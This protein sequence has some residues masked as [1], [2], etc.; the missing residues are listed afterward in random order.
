[1]LW[2]IN[3]S[4]CLHNAVI[5][6]WVLWGSGCLVMKTEFIIQH[7]YSR[8]GTWSRGRIWGFQWA[9]Q[10]SFLLRN[11]ASL[12]WALRDNPIPVF[13]GCSMLVSGALPQCEHWK[14]RKEIK[15]WECKAK[16]F[17]A[18][19]QPLNCLGLCCP[20]GEYRASGP[21]HCVFVDLFSLLS[22][23]YV[24]LD[25]FLL[26]ASLFSPWLTGSSMLVKLQLLAFCFC[27]EILRFWA[28]WL[29]PSAARPLVPLRW[30][31][32]CR[33]WCRYV[34]V[35]HL[36]RAVWN[37]SECCVSP[38]WRYSLSKG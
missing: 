12:R 10:N 38:K 6:D 24:V 2:A 36:T 35:L 25:S 4:C 32:L 9:K 3:T 16:E 34:T 27:Y 30:V 21:R 33:L 28:A 37:N 14:G 1:M 22:C 29:L 18:S 11:F 26:Y 19:S 17:P 5:V 13:K 7:Y 8:Q 31:L 23:S 20:L 15:C